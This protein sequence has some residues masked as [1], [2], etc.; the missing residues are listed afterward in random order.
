M[1]GLA[2]SG[3]NALITSVHIQ[4]VVSCFTV[5]FKGLPQRVIVSMALSAATAHPDD[6][7]HMIVFYAASL[8]DQVSNLHDGDVLGRHWRKLQF[9]NMNLP[10][11]SLLS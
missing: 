1:N 11:S 9:P 4:S 5:G 2:A 3:G 10:R 6:F 8:P 7:D